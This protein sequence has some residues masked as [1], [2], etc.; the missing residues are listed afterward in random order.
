M[1]VAITGASS[2][3]GAAIA[4]E[5]ASGNRLTLIAR[6]K[7]LLDALADEVD[8][9]AR[10]FVRDLSIVESCA[11]WIAEAE[12]ANGPID[13]LVNN[14]GI[15]IIGPAHKADVEACEKLL[16]LNVHT[17]MRLTRAVLPG[18]IERG[19]GTIVDIASAAALAPTPGMFYYNASKGAL[20]AASEALRGEL[21]D[22][23]VHVVTVYPGIIA[24]T[25]MG[26]KGLQA[27]QSSTLEKLQPRGTTAELARQ[28]HTAIDY[29]KP[30]VI[31]PAFNAL[32]RSFPGV[33]RWM[34][35]RFTPPLRES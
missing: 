5:M 35:D 9:V 32:A 17:P 29:K 18:M 30:R 28:I 22:T 2:G 19:R 27:Y 10:V 25:D 24:E 14:A 15:Q 4:K 11:D 3:I 31:Y 16:R 20:A 23:G 6:R 26:Q 12:A 13:I 8:C 7:E 21:I 33:T 1:H 34:M